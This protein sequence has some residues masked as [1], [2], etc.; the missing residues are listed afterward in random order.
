MLSFATWAIILGI[1]AVVFPTLILVLACKL[2]EKHAVNFEK[3]MK[4]FAFIFV[5]FLICLI[6]SMFG[7]LSSDELITS[8]ESL[9]SELKFEEAKLSN[10]G[11]SIVVRHDFG[12][13]AVPVE[14]C[15]IEE[16]EEQ[17]LKKYLKTIEKSWSFFLITEK[18]VEKQD[19]YRLS[20]NID[21]LN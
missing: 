5:I 12:I 3:V 4:I 17:V 6:V 19:L 13:I 2:N 11:T 9:I 15:I 8:N 16:G 10:D 7:A 20:T 1:S 18:E 21:I 14:N